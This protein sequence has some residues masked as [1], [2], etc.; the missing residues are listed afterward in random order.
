MKLISLCLD[1]DLTEPGFTF[2]GG[3]SQTSGQRPAR[4]CIRAGRGD[5]GG[6]LLDSTIGQN[7]YNGATMN[8]YKLCSLILKFNLNSR[9]QILSCLLYRWRTTWK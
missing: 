5:W 9:I 7:F 4:P 8:I 3:F 6:F 2:S 1:E